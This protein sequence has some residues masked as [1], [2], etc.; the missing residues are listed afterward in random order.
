MIKTSIIVP[1]D[2]SAGFYVNICLG[3]GGAFFIFTFLKNSALY[4]RN[5]QE[6]VIPNFL[7]F[8]TSKELKAPFVSVLA[9]LDR[10]CL[11]S[12]SIRYYIVLYRH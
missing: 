8:L 4:C 5:V 1:P 3:W 7:Y 10:R 2:L 6:F 11:R 12:T 9:S